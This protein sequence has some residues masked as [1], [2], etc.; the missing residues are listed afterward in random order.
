MDVQGLASAAGLE[1]LERLQGNVGPVVRKPGEDPVGLTLDLGY[2]LFDQE[3][4]DTVF[5]EGT[6]ELPEDPDVV[7]GSLQSVAL[8]VERALQGLA[9]FKLGLE[10]RPLL[11]QPVAPGTQVL[12]LRLKHTRLLLSSP[13]RFKGGPQLGRSGPQALHPSGNLPFAILRRLEVG[14]DP[15]QL[16]FS[17]QETLPR[18]RRIRQG[19]QGSGDSAWRSGS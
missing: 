14:A 7:S 13:L 19:F 8:S 3:G 18:L 1:V 12:D 15:V 6:G 16:A 4:R 17:R 11:D 10:L 9:S 5:P 2:G